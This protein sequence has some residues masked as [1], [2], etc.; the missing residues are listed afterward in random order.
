MSILNLFV[1]LLSFIQE[2][3][4]TFLFLLYGEPDV[5]RQ[6]VE[7]VQEGVNVRVVFVV[8]DQNVVKLSEITF[9]FRDE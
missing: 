9:N 7:V 6:T 2:D 8:E 5:R 4:L 1:P 3:N